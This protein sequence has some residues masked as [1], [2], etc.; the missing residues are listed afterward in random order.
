M[1][2]RRVAALR[3]SLADAHLSGLLLTSLANIRY[4]TGFS[5]SSALVVVTA[6]HVVLVTDFR[7]QTQVVAEVGDFARVVIE[8]QSL[9]TALWRALEGL[10]AEILGFESS[11]LLHRD[12]QRLLDGPSQWQWRPATDLVE[13][14]RERKDA[15][16]LAHIRQAVATAEHALGETVPRIAAGMTELAVAGMLENALRNAGSEA[17]PFPTIVAAGGRSALPHAR[18]STRLIGKNEWLLIDF[19]AV[20]NGYC[21]DIT[22][23]FFVGHADDRHREVYEIVL[24]A[25]A[26][27]SAAVVPGMS[28][29][30]ADAVARRYIE[31]RG[32]G[33]AFGHSLGHGI[34]LEVHEAPRLAAT[35]EGLLPAGAV[36]TIEPGIYLPDWGGVRI[37][38]DVY[39]DG[40]GSRILTTFT[41]ELLELA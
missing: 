14:L 25:N 11:H 17:F 35:A 6:R 2:P 34:G 5:G 8:P 16:E 4:I 18:S 30:D 40:S 31:D 37:E 19:G 12:F 41:R 15:D 28:G 38:D 26:L 10:D 32:H 21:S 39:L 29:R 7:Y 23:T 22:R 36:V 27:S 3:Q 24:E 1:R 9:W 20:V 13:R 33:A